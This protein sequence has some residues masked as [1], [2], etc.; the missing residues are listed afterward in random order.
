MGSEGLPGEVLAIREHDLGRED[1]ETLRTKEALAGC[2]HDA[3]KPEEAIEI[4]QESLSGTTC[5]Q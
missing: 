4:F 2:L 3:A 5:V 1:L